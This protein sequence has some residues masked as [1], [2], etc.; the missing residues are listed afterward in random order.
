M[1]HLS[2]KTMEKAND[3]NPPAPSGVNKKLAF[4]KRCLESMSSK[5]CTVSKEGGI[6]KVG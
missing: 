6:T 4:I 2:L 5:V 1:Y 3:A